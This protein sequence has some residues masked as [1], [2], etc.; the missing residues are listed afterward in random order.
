MALAIYYQHFAADITFASPSPAWQIPPARLAEASQRLL[1][2]PD[3]ESCG[4]PDRRRLD[5]VDEGGAFL[6]A[7]GGPWVGREASADPAR[8]DLRG[9]GPGARSRHPVHG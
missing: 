7:R 9:A 6:E 1:R 5:C 4:P 3:A 2:W 8:C